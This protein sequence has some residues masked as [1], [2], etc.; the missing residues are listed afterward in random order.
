MQETHRNIIISVVASIVLLIFLVLLF[1]NNAMAQNQTF[2]II[3]TVMILI[4]L[5]FG[6]GFYI[7]TYFNEADIKKKDK[8]PDHFR[9]INEILKSMGYSE[10]YQWEKGKDVRYDTRKFD[11]IEYVAMLGYRVYLNTYMLVIYDTEHKDIVRFIDN[12]PFRMQMDLFY[13]FSPKYINKVELIT[14]AYGNR[15]RR[16]PQQII[17]GAPPSPQPQQQEPEQKDGN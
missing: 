8:M 3:G 9:N 11:N 7:Y 1:K 6:L 16:S 5:L 10:V 13:N 15:H 4:S 12:P 17:I 14:S 2:Y